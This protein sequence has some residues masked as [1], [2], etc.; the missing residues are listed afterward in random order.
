MVLPVPTGA[1]SQ[2][3]TFWEIAQGSNNSH[4]ATRTQLY[5]GRLYPVSF[6]SIP[7]GL[8]CTQAVQSAS[9]FTQSTAVTQ[10]VVTFELNKRDTELYPCF[11]V[12][13]LCG[14]PRKP[15]SLQMQPVC[16]ILPESQRMAPAL[17][18]LT[19][20]TWIFLKSWIVLSCLGT[21]TLAVGSKLLPVPQKSLRLAASEEGTRNVTRGSFW[22]PGRQCTPLGHLLFCLYAAGTL[23]SCQLES[24]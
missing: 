14:R 20:K 1:L 13:R 6:S 24:C 7:A 10:C 11:K 3:G 8:L 12:Q 22:L 9:F 17:V 16:A 23:E 15:A 4:W 18:L 19:G 2:P 5:C 21:G